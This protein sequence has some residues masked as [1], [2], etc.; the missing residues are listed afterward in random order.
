[1]TIG[2]AT[3]DGVSRD[4]NGAV[5]SNGVVRIVTEGGRVV[6]ERCAV[7][8]TVISRLKGLLGRKHL[9]SGDGLLLRPA[10]MVHTWF[11]RFAIDVV[12]VDADMRVVGITHDAGPWRL[13]GRR[14]ARS[15][16]ELPAG[17][18]RR[19]GIQHGAKLRVEHG[20]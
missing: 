8:D 20:S 10:N 3:K 15:V 9:H 12:F 13:T 5:Q 17:E 11:M 19:R 14:G 7:A 18:C 4:S 1:M 16:I 2:G 6:C